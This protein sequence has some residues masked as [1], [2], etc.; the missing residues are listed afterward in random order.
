MIGKQ[1]HVP[2]T[3]RVIPI[4]QDEYVDPAFGTG[5]VKITPAHDF[6]DWEVGTRHEME[7]INLLT[8]DAKMNENAPAAY[9]GLDRFE[10]R[11]QIVKDLQQAQLLVNV[12]KH[13]YKRPRGDRSGCVIE[14]YLTDQWYVDLTRE[15]LDDDRPGGKQVIT[16]PSIE[17]VRSGKVKF[18]PKNWENTYFQWLE[19]IQD[20]CISRQLWWGH[21]IPA[22][23]DEAG[24]VYVA[25]S[26]IAVRAKYQLDDNVSLRQD[27]DVLDTWFSS[28][29]WPFSTLGWPDKSQRLAQFY[30]TSVLVTGFDIIFFWVARMIMA[31]VTFMQ[32]VPFHEVYITGLV[33]DSHGQ[34]MSK[35]KGNVL[36]PV[37]FIDGISLD[38]L[39][40]K[41][42]Q[43]MM[44]THLREKV[45][46]QTKQDFPEGI[47]AYGTDALRF[48]FAAMATNGRDINFATGRIEGYRNF[49]NKIWNAARFVLSNTDGKDNA[50]DHDDY[51]LTT[52]DQWIISRLQHAGNLVL[53]GFEGY[54]FDRVSTA[55]YEFIWNEYCDWYLELS[56]PILYK[57]STS[58]RI[59][60][61][62]RRTLLRVLEVAMRL[63]HP[64]MP[65]ITEHVWQQLAP[66]VGNTHDTI[67]L[68]PYPDPDKE[69]QDIKAELSVQWLQD[70]ILGIRKIRGE[71]DIPPGKLLSVFIANVSESDQLRINEH[72]S[73]LQF[74]GR[75]SEISVLDDESEAPE[76]ATAMVGELKIMIPLK[77]LIDKDVELERLQKEL[78]KVQYNVDRILNK[79]NNV[80]FVQ[81]A[82]STIVDK[83]REKLSQGQR[84]IL[85]LGEQVEKMKRL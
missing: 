7:V 42:T 39:V 63:A 73:L 67:M 6:N 22:W 77:G 65:F 20:W 74:V 1:V 72:H 29:L 33:R 61:G 30:P 15:R 32:D 16:N 44:Q 25:E 55:I 10:A 69:K 62:T 83:E 28:A 5:C 51:Q 8:P 54:R 48:T 11:E 60:I 23:Y 40:T 79:V 47:K 45:C 75:V 56:K 81:N 49:C 34:K 19:N 52:V 26:E 71:M 59:K 57:K 37:D 27:E 18:V 31:G 68:E 2:L 85:T 13:T 82:P 17:A 4:I 3:D 12:K 78:S 24:K 21:R 80:Q 58:E 43:G 53:K 70:F 35:S 50:I 66:R 64:L 84:L 46:E 76:S 14:P 41:R 38:A 36:D 9:Q